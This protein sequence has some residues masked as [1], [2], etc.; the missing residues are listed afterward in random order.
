VERAFEKDDKE[1]KQTARKM[2]RMMF[3]INKDNFD[4]HQE[5]TCYTCHRGAHKPVT[6]PVISEEE[7]VHT[8]EQS[9]AG[10]PTADQ[11]LEKYLQAVGGPVAVA[12]ISDRIQKGTLTVGSEHFPVEILAKAPAKRLSTVHFAGGD[13]IT[14]INGE[15]GWLS[16]PGRPV[17]D[18]SPSELDSAVVEA[19]AFFPGRLKQMFNQFR[20]ESKEQVAGRETYIVMGIRDNRSPVQIY[21]DT[22][23]GLLLRMLRYTETPLGRNPTQTDFADYREQDGVKV[24]FRWTISR[25]SGR[26][27][28]QIEQM[29]QNVP[30]D[31]KRFTKP[32]PAPQG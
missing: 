12:K 29:Q 10:L 31:D 19:E 14:G 9:F 23:S 17:H 25:P 24:P 8:G 7:N 15:E 28:I 3:A 26:F 4:G 30:I 22:Q 20:V 11:V 18:M 27:T 21:V 13:S 32:A 16:P 2:M 6:T 1:N 5:V